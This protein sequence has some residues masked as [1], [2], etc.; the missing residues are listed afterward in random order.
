MAQGKYIMFCDSDDFYE[1]TMCEKMFKA[2]EENNVDFAICNTNI[3]NVSN[4]NFDEKNSYFIN[5]IFGKNK[6]SQKIKENINIVIWNKIF[7][8]DLIDRY[9][10]SFP[11]CNHAEDTSFFYNYISVSNT[12]YGLEEKLYNHL[13]RHCSLVDNFENGIIT[14]ENDDAFNSI[15]HT[16]NFLM[17]N[18]LFNK[19]MNFFF[20]VLFKFIFF[21]TQNYNYEEKLEIFKMLGTTLEKFKIKYPKNFYGNLFKAMAKKDYQKAIKLYDK[22]HFYLYSENLSFI[23]HLFS[24]KNV[25]DKKIISILGIKFN[26]KKI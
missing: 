1:P 24:I 8:K 22:H 13:F 16:F 12:F 15:L 18:N 7:K 9:N 14:K 23:Q 5:N 2:I 21:H 20:T 17:K 4:R 10:I 26:L 11:K 3:I 6:L 25:A 19:N